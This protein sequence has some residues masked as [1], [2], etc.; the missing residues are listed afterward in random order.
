MLY[1]VEVDNNMYSLLITNVIDFWLQFIFNLD[2]SVYFVVFDL[3]FNSIWIILV[4]F[5]RISNLTSMSKEMSPVAF[6]Q[7]SGNK[8]KLNDTKST[9]S[10]LF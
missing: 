5:L 10:E 2:T 8:S 1:S 6:C 3:N 4:T 7:P 9:K